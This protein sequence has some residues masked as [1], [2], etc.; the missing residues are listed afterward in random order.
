MLAQELL[1]DS[2]L[3]NHIGEAKFFFTADLYSTMRML[4]GNP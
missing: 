3:I 2:L 1:N 4:F